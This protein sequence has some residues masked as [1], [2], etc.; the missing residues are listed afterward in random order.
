MNIKI[1]I[2][3]A[4]DMSLADAEKSNIRIVPLKVFFG[5]KMY[6]D[7]VTL[8]HSE[9]YEKLIE[10]TRLPTTSQITPYEFGQVFREETK[11]GNK[12][13]CI[14]VSGKL[15]GTNQS[16]C[17]AAKDFENVAVVDSMNGS[18]GERI[19]ADYGVSLIKRGKS[20]EEIV[21]TLNEEKN[22]IRLM[23]M[24]DT[25]EYLKKG[26]RISSSVAFAGSLLAIKPV[27]AVKDGELYL[28]GKARGSKAVNN[29]I[30][31]YI[32]ECGGID[33]DKPFYLAYSGT[34]RD[35]L[36]KYIRDNKDLYQ[37]YADNIP[38]SSIGAAIG[39]HCGPGTIVAAFFAKTK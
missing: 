35:M 39:T 18:I 14:T 11:A 36:D 27:L 17:L 9:F 29:K 38:V 30:A 8:S 20:F 19:L 24:L 5:D 23:A 16:A 13:I 26:G 7:N 37:D 33:F 6:L 15:S 32:H 12:I 28:H 4:C 34:S 22:N 2:D 25:L 21:E 31:E 10:S 1:V 3:S